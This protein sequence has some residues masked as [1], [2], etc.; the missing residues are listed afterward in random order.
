[1]VKPDHFIVG[2]PKCGTTALSEYL[3]THPSIF[4]STPKEPHFFATDLPGYQKSRTLEQYF[5]LFENDKHQKS[6][7]GEVSVYYLYSKVAIGNL[8]NF[9]RDARLIVMLRRPT[10]LIYSL[11][12]QLL[13]SRNENIYD[14]KQA[15]DAQPH[16]RKGQ[17]IP[18]SCTD[19]KVL[20]YKSVGML[21]QQLK[22]LLSSSFQRSQIHIIFLR[23]LQTIL[24]LFIKKYSTFSESMMMGMKK[25]LSLIQTLDIGYFG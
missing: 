19:P 23:T 10:Q 4:M 8:F 13:Y 9:N 2:G 21:S 25:S 11:H 16:R 14:F 5:A 1:M 22:R 12:S 3:R 7:Y 15:W 17:L 18:Y 24:E 20:Q 6:R